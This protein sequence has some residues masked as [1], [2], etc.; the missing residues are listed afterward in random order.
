MRGGDRPGWHPVDDRRIARFRDR[1]AL[2]HRSGSEKNSRPWDPPDNKFERMLQG[3]CADR[4]VDPFLV[5][6][7][8]LSKWDGT[9]RVE[10][11]LADLLGADR[12]DP[13]T[14]WASRYMFVGA[15]ERAMSPGCKIDEFPV[16]VGPQG[17]GKSA[18]VKSLL[19]QE[20]WFGDDLD[21]S[22]SP[23]EQAESIA[24]RVIV[25]VSE[26]AGSRKADIDHM[27]AFLTRTNDGQH[28]AAYARAPESSPRRCIFVGSAN[29]SGVGILPNDTSGNRRFVIVEVRNALQ[30]VEPALAK[31]R[32]QLWA[33]GLAKFRDGTWPTA[34]FPR[35]LQ[36][37][38]AGRN[39]EWRSGNMVIE[40]AIAGLL[41]DTEAPLQELM[42]RGEIDQRHQRAF[43]QM[44]RHRGWTKRKDQEDQPQ[45][46]EAPGCWKKRGRSYDPR[47]SEGDLVVPLLEPL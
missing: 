10:S 11:L 5:W 8:G 16:L 25:E 14:L 33:E 12:G 31:M 6:L 43:T 46:V 15:I 40:D 29:D 44:L 23:K 27:K 20:D 21:L 2:T 38:Q 1:V 4:E 24:G 9:P 47:L 37:E 28:R 7:E 39:E 18:L 30:E 34:R 19:P 13:Q 26:M 42:K 17:A 36:H 41:P 45:H 3:Y 32:D 22:S 35:E